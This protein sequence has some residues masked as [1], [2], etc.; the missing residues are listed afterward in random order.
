[1]VD[2]KDIISASSV[3]GKQDVEFY[4]I[5]PLIQGDAIQ[6]DVPE[7]FTQFNDPNFFL[8]KRIS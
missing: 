6:F 8:I 1:M 3:T 5:N 2:F 7:T 4:P